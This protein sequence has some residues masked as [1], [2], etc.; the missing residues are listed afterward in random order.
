MSAR[1]IGAAGALLFADCCLAGIVDDGDG[2]GAEHVERT[3][4]FCMV[5]MSAVGRWKRPEL[6]GSVENGAEELVHRHHRRITR[7]QGNETV[8]DVG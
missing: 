5:G 1:T 7:R 2:A 6:R 4:N 8:A 3:R